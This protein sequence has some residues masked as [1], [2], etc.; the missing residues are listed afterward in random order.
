MCLSQS[1]DS[2]KSY[3]KGVQL[4][5]GVK[6]AAI[7]DWDQSTVFSIEDG[8]HELVTIIQAVCTDGKALIPSVIC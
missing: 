7:I 5:L 3:E 4:G 8:N 1:Q 6:V 2:D